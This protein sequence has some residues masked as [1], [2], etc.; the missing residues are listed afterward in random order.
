MLMCLSVKWKQSHILHKIVMRTKWNIKDQ[1]ICSFSHPIAILLHPPFLH[2]S[3]ISL[4]STICPICWEKSVDTKEVQD[5]L[6]NGY[7]EQRA[8][9]RGADW[10]RASL[11]GRNGC[12]AKLWDVSLPRSSAVSPNWLS[13][14]SG[15]SYS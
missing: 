8:R 7:S 1:W 15:L 11:K 12:R 4:L 2:L 3:G 9:K 10:S 6:W 13:A 5:A 14:D